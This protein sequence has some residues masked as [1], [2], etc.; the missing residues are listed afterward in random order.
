MSKGAGENINPTPP[1]PILTPAEATVM[2]LGIH[3]DTGS[4]TYDGATP[5]DAA[6]LAWLMAQ[7]AS[8]PVIAEY[9]DPGLSPKLQQLLKEALEKL[10]ADGATQIILD[11]RGNPGGLL[12]E[13]V[14]ICNLFVPKN[15][16][17]VTTK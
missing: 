5:R 6:A 11:L 10:K 12:H 13:A 15:E 1:A 17:I 8:L 16:L 9:I 14:N 4:L 7:G 2:A 3:V